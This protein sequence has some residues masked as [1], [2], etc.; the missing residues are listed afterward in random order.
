MIKPTYALIVKKRPKW[1]LDIFIIRLYEYL[2]LSK[3]MMNHY[4]YMTNDL[5]VNFDRYFKVIKNKEGK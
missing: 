1:Y 4:R 2:G 5:E 3:Q